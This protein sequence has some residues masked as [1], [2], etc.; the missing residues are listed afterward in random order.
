MARGE[1]GLVLSAMMMISDSRHFELDG[2]P[3][4]IVFQF[5]LCCLNAFADMGVAA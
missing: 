5:G 4:S 2:Q 3:H 1:F